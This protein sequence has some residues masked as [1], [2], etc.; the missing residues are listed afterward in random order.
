MRSRFGSEARALRNPAYTP[1]WTLN[2]SSA[3]HQIKNHPKGG[4]YDVGNLPVFALASANPLRQRRACST[5]PC[6]RP[7]SRR[8]DYRELRSKLKKPLKVAF[9]TLVVGRNPVSNSCINRP[10]SASGKPAEACGKAL[11]PATPSSLTVTFRILSIL[12]FRS[13]QGRISTNSRR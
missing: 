3:K 1:A 9:L 2:G 8:F 4:L 6:L 5:K 12:S 13:I 11:R 10:A 7:A